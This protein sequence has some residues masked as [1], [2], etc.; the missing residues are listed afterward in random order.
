[1][2]FVKALVNEMSFNLGMDLIENLHVDRGLTV[3]FYH[4]IIT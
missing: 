4:T 2:W 3:S 1:M